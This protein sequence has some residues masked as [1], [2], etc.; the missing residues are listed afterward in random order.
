MRR[1][2]NQAKKGGSA[3]FSILELVVVIAILALVAAIAVP[4]LI[5]AVHASRLRG[6]A[7]DFAALLQQAR[8]RA[9]QDDRYYSLYLLPN[10]NQEFVDIYPQA[11]NG[12][13][14]SNGQTLDSRDPV[15]TLASEVN[16]QP[17]GAAPGTATLQTQFLGKN[18][19]AAA[20]LAAPLDGSVSAVTFG[21][22]GVP[23]LPNPVAG[24]TVCNSTGGLT[25][26]WVFF[27]DA[28]TQN[29]EAVTVTPAGRIQKWNYTSGV[30]GKI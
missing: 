1:W 13:S 11:V 25:A 19:G 15:I 20:P 5:T 10:T 2:D 6:A 30:W 18:A 12:A 17:Q 29:W 3:G 4:N 21:P 23:C 16:L 8:M 27:Q 28:V 7:S 9:V 26:Y 24:G 14:G 22:E